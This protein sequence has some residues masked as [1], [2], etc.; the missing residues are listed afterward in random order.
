MIHNAQQ[1]YKVHLT[2][3]NQKQLTSANSLISCFISLTNDGVSEINATRGV[4]FKPEIC[5]AL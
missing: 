1:K 3:F 2:I 5:I 4:P